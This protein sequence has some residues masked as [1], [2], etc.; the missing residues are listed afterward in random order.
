MTGAEIVAIISVSAGA[1]TTILSTCFQS[2]CTRINTPCI[3]CEREL[4]KDE[5]DQ[6]HNK[7]DKK[8]K[9]NT[10]NESIRPEI[11]PVR[12]NPSVTKN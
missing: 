11:P 4:P 8:D 6:D 3:K 1:L 12:A 2:R 7:K 9:E 10:E 5:H